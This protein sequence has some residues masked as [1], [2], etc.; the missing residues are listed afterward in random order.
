M[1]ST[2]L[3][4]NPPGAFRSSRPYRK[5]FSPAASA[6]CAAVRILRSATTEPVHDWPGAGAA[7]AQ[8]GD[9]G[10]ELV[11]G[12]VLAVVEQG[13]GVGR[14]GDGVALEVGGGRVPRCGGRSRQ[15]QER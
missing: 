9:D 13:A 4:R 2:T 8:A 14:G 7:L 3:V 12:G 6:Q 1:Y 15:G 5:L 11:D 10:G